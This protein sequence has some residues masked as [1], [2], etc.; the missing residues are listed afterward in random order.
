[1][2]VVFSIYIQTSIER[3]LNGTFV[4]VEYTVV[5][6]E[7]K[8]IVAEVRLKSILRHGTV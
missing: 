8:C 7:S 2:V 5:S 4:K 1:V 6:K 3:W